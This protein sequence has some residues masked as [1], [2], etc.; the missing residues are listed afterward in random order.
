MKEDH[1]LMKG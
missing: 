1:W